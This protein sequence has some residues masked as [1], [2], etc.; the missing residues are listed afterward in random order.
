LKIVA[1]ALLIAVSVQPVVTA[2][3]MTEKIAATDRSVVSGKMMSAL[4]VDASPRAAI[5]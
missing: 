3:K 5:N 1:H 4:A 2:L